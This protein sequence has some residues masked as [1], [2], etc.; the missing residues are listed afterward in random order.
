MKYQA[1]DGGFL[2]PVSTESNVDRQWQNV[3]NHQPDFI[4]M[5][6]IEEVGALLDVNVKPLKRGPYKK[7][8]A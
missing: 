8:S 7:K 1:R 6:L 5:I 4:K 3:K 2:L